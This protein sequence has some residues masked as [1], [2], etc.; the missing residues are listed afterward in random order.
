MNSKNKLL[1]SQVGFQ[2]QA[3]KVRKEQEFIGED[4]KLYTLVLAVRKIMVK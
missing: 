3:K 2:A 4:T 1:L